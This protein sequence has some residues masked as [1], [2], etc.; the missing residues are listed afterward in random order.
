MRRLV[1]A[2]VI[3][4]C[5]G[6]VDARPLYLQIYQRTFPLDGGQKSKCNIC[7]FGDSKQHRN[8]YG[9]RFEAKLSGKNVKDAEEIR[10]ILLELGPNRVRPQD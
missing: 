8:G 7:H 1:I 2:A 10:R 9:K 3:V 4:L 6:S 5:G